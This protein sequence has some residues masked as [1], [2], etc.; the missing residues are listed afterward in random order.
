LTPKAVLEKLAAIQMLDV[1]LPTSDGRY[2][3]MPRFT[4]PEP[5]QAILLHKLQ[6]SLP[7][8]PPPRIQAKS[9]EF[10]QQALRL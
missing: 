2:L 9:N 10:P 5:H 8:Q 7:A 6:L 3:I 1:C 4:Q